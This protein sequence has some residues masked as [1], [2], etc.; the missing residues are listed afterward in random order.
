MGRI[1]D[2]IRLSEV[3]AGDLLKYVDTKSP[4]D[5]LSLVLLLDQIP[6]NSY[7]D[8]ES[9]VVFNHYDPIALDIT[10]LAIKNE[11]PEHPLLRY[12]LG[13]RLWFYLPLMHSEKLDVHVLAVKEY[14][15]MRRDVEELEPEMPNPNDELDYRARLTQKKELAKTLCLFQLDA[16]DRHRKIIEQLGRYPHRND[17]LG[18]THTAEG[19]E[20]LKNG[21]ETFDGRSLSANT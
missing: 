16:E 14:R 3:V 19:K 2:S 17:V 8:S 4:L 5:W 9:R 18:R 12:Q 11:I 15:Q 13:Y 7:R 21:G 6:R 10:F 1:L 20:Y